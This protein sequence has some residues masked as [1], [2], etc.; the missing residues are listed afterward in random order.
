MNSSRTLSIIGAAAVI[1]ALI[2]TQLDV[3]DRNKTIAQQI[4]TEAEKTIEIVSAGDADM[5]IY[6]TLE[7]V[8]QDADLIV[9]AE[10]VGE[11]ATKNMVL[12]S[13]V[14]ETY[15]LAK[16]KVN[17]V[18]KGEVQEGDELTIAEPG[19]FDGSGKYVSFEG[20][21][22]MEKDGRYILFLRTGTNNEQIV[23]GLYQGKFDLTLPKLE[24]EMT[25]ARMSVAEFDQK[26][27]V[28]DSVWQFNRLKKQVLEKYSTVE[29]YR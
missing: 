25:N 5:M 20:Y 27:Y 22:L 21:K 17:H 18:Y 26:D 10:L 24:Q 12:N 28:G 7:Q 13:M 14:I 19:Y 9:A 1:G 15:G 3:T 23:I 2:F 16:V 11:R 8:E 6:S 29:S 4:S